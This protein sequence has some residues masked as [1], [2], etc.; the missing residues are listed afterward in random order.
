MI[1]SGLLWVSL[2]HATF[3]LVVLDG[4]VVEAAPIARYAL[5]WSLGRAVG[6]FGRRGRVEWLPD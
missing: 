4:M 2:P 1:D 6:Y 5:G 3:G